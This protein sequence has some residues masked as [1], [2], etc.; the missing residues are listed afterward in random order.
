M[1]HSGHFLVLGPRPSRLGQT[2]LVGRTWKAAL[3]RLDD[4]RR[5]V[6]DDEARRK[7]RAFCLGPSREGTGAGV[8][9][10]PVPS[11]RAVNHK[12]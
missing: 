12:Y 10:H 8:A 2:A 4:H 3:N 7:C 6:R 1:T 11:S 5:A 9:L